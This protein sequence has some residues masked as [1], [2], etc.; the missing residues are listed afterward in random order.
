M[1]NKK[2]ELQNT[3]DFSELSKRLNEQIH[4]MRDEQDE[5]VFSFIQTLKLPVIEETLKKLECLN[6]M[7]QI[8]F[9]P[10]YDRSSLSGYYNYIV[11]GFEKNTLKLIYS[12]HTRIHELTLKYGVTTS[13]LI[14]PSKK[15]SICIYETKRKFLCI[16]RRLELSRG[17]SFS[18][19]KASVF[20]DETEAYK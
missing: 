15:N 17:Q 4:T 14:F 19:K 7:Y 6:R 18:D 8:I 20:Y 2:I 13:A 16:L 12:E 11:A 5:K 9:E 3:D 1:S 10:V